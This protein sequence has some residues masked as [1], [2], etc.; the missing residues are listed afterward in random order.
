M[1]GMEAKE[2]K[3]EEVV[4]FGRASR[5]VTAASRVLS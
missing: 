3:K 4:G 2:V 5:R 1:K